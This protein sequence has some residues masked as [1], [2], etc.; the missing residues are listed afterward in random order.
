MPKEEYGSGMKRRK[1]D[2]KKK[3]QMDRKVNGGMGLGKP[4]PKKK[5]IM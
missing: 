1:E 4:R 5:K 2:Q 3:E